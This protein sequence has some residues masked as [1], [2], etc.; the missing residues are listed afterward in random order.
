MGSP[1]VSVVIPC[2]RQGRFLAGAVESALAQSYPSVEVIVVNDGSD[3]DTEEVAGR[4]GDRIRYVYQT[5]R[6]LAGA[7][8]A[9][10][11]QARGEYLLFL[12]SDD[13]LH[14]EAVAWL[15]GAAGGRDDVLCSAGY[16]RFADGQ[17]PATGTDV[18]PPRAAS[19]G[20]QLL[21]MCFGPPHSFLSPRAKVAALGGF[22]AGPAGC[23]D[24][25]LWVRLVLAGCE[26]APVFRV[27][28]Y[29]RQHP[30]SMST[31]GQLMGTGCAAVLRRVL[32]V[33]EQS[34]ATIAALGRDPDELRR[35]VRRRI[36]R[37]L[38]DAGYASC[39]KGRLRAAL[40]FYLASLRWGRLAA[41]GGIG[42]LLPYQLRRAI[43]GH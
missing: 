10:L 42:K 35:D 32:A 24:Y 23:E 1:L 3:D 43:R 28:A 14:P 39:Q 27:A 25:D 16:R 26:V 22:D 29:Y 31:S 21:S 9:G 15:V 33:A 19:P 34:P 20:G 8:N 13:L 40:Y 4:Y 11:A 7:R 12:D 37:E 30:A 5:N 6:G 41:L 2:F 36:G 17:G 18:L 38:F